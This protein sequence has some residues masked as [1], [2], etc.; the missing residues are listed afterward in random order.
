MPRLFTGRHL[1]GKKPGLKVRARAKKT[2][3]AYVSI[4]DVKSS[5]SNQGTRQHIGNQPEQPGSRFLKKTNR[6]SGISKEEFG[7]ITQVCVNK[8]NYF[9]ALSGVHSGSPTWPWKGRTLEALWLV[10]DFFNTNFTQCAVDCD[11]LRK[12]LTYKSSS[13]PVSNLSK[14]QLV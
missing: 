5:Q 7:F 4:F 14:P 13:L 10:F 6:S 9:T 8:F 12:I 1:P 11:D 3:T 2:N